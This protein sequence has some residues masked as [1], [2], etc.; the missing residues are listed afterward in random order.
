FG[1][2]P[3]AEES[4][5]N[6]AAGSLPL[7]FRIF[8]LTI[9]LAGELALLTTWLF[10]TTQVVATQHDWA[11]LFLRS[12]VCFVVIVAPFGYLRNRP[13]IE[14]INAQSRGASRIGIRWHL[15]AAHLATLILAVH[16]STVLYQAGGL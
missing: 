1:S 4:R 9:L 13:S 12:V 7:T 14:A 10:H 5:V 16:L 11:A 6:I 2:L 15:L 3:V 8:L